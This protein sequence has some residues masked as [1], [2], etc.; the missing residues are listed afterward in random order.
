[1]ISLSTYLFGS[2][3]LSSAVVYHAFSTREQFYP[4]MLFLSTSKLS[5]VIMGNMA[6]ALTLVLGQVLKKIFLGQLRE[7]EVERLCERS[8]DAITETC[9]AMTIFREEFNA[10]FVAMFVS[11]LFIKLGHW[12]SQDRVEY[13]EITPAVSRLAHLRIITFLGLLLLVDALFLQYTMG[14]TLSREPSILLYFAFEYVILASGTVSTFLK[15]GLYV[16]DMIM[17]G[18]WENKGVYVFYLELVTDLLHLFVYLA[19]F[20]IILHT[21]GFPLHLM[22]EL[23]WTFRNFRNRVADFIRYRRVTANMNERFPDATPE[24][25]VRSDAICI[26]CREEMTSAKKLPCGH[27]FHTHCLRSWLERQQQAS[28]CPTCRAPV[29]IDPTPPAAPEAPAPNMNN[30]NRA[31][32]DVNAGGGVGPAP[33]PMPGVPPATGAPGVRPAAGPHGVHRAANWGTGVNPTPPMAANNAAAGA[34]AGQPQ[35]TQGRTGVSPAGVAG[36]VPAPLGNNWREWLS[37]NPGGMIPGAQ[38]AAVSGAPWSTAQAQSMP[39]YAFGGFPPAGFTAAPPQQTT[40]A[41]NPEQHAIAA[42]A[43]AAA[44]VAVSMY[45]FTPQPGFLP[46]TLFPGAAQPGAETG[47][48]GSETRAGGATEPNLAGVMQ[49]LDVLQRELPLL[50]AQQRVALASTVPPAP[51]PP[52]GEQVANGAGGHD[53]HVLSSRTAVGVF[54]PTSGAGSSA[55]AG[56]SADP[57]HPPCSDVKGKGKIGEENVSLDVNPAVPVAVE[58]ECS[59]AGPMEPSPKPVQPNEQGDADYT[60]SQTKEPI[61]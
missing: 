5:V 40:V 8:K 15:Y 50:V 26:I 10:N 7:S 27:L 44:A 45:M 34:P 21:Y 24:E 49:A 6:F 52:S 58:G 1:M 9:L 20:L 28:T 23:Y 37:Q 16:V 35:A 13:I 22:R 60:A 53:T 14:M 56:P 43:A 46:T 33:A 38:D 55:G 39:P 61:E 51:P 41:T 4:A 2:F 19:F 36:S 29:L 12:L 54:A 48:G 47:A 18:R 59:S 11:L 32:G 17:E 57:V 30:N 31:P 25:I 3:A 42:A